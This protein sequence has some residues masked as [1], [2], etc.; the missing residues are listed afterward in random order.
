L[1]ASFWGM[2]SAKEILL[3]PA[4]NPEATDVPTAVVVVMKRPVAT[5][6]E[7]VLAKLQLRPTV[8]QFYIPAVASAELIRTIFPFYYFVARERV[9]NLIED[10]RVCAVR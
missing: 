6:S 4:T 2:L 1:L 9:V 5:V 10:A 7:R 3:S 8:P